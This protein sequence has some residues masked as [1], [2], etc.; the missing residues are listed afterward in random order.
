MLP[1][2]G[3]RVK[4]SCCA[5]IAAISEFYVGGGAVSVAECKSDKKESELSRQAFDLFNQK[6]P[7]KMF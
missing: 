2:Q 4:L 5:A 3:L 1:A 6:S 7:Q